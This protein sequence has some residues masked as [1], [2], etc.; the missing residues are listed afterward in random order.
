MINFTE[1]CKNIL[2]ITFIGC[3]T[4][5]NEALSQLENLKDSLTNLE[6]N[7]CFNVSD[8]GILALAKIS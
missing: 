4:V 6:I 7:S 2:N 3:Q 8:K 5:N 1:N